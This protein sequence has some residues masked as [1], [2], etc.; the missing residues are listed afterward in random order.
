[1]TF[2]RFKRQ[3]A[4]TSETTATRPPSR[5]C[6]T[7][8]PVRRTSSAQATA[9]CP[10]QTVQRDQRPRSAEDAVNTGHGGCKL[11]DDLPPWRPHPSSGCGKRRAGRATRSESVYT[12]SLRVSRGGPRR[13]AAIKTHA[14]LSLHVGTVLQGHGSCELA[15]PSV[16]KPTIVC[17]EQLCPARSSRRQTHLAQLGAHLRV[18]RQAVVAVVDVLCVTKLSSARSHQFDYHIPSAPVLYRD[19]NA[20]EGSCQTASGRSLAESVWLASA[21]TRSRGLTIVVRCEKCR[22]KRASVI[23]GRGGEGREEE[24][25]PHTTT[26]TESHARAPMSTDDRRVSRSRAHAHAPLDANLRLESQ[27]SDSV[28][29]ASARHSGRTCKYAERARDLASFDISRP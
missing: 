27:E 22:C 11:D 7:S 26:T 15:A 28:L 10:W 17:A 9:S 6:F 4:W 8:C 14:D 19:A 18:L 2:L 12:Q 20:R 1:M 16:Q 5:K 29:I 24:R 13:S 3:Q 23:N 21:R 25:G